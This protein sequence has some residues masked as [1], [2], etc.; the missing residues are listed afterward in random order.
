VPASSLMSTAAPD[1]VVILLV[2]QR[3]FMNGIS[4]EP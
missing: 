1:T 2:R 3:S 4:T